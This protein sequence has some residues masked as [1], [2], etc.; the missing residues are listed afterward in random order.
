MIYAQ[1]LEKSIFQRIFFNWRIDQHPGCQS[2][3]S[4]SSPTLGYPARTTPHVRTPNDHSTTTSSNTTP[5]TNRQ[6]AGRPP[7]ISISMQLHRHQG[8]QCPVCQ[9][10]S[11][12]SCHVVALAQPDSSS[13]SVCHRGTTLFGGPPN[14]CLPPL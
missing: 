9:Q 4:S 5:K 14:H 7:T 8:C 2:N 10:H 3:L 6:Q 13:H 12:A 1:N 11:D